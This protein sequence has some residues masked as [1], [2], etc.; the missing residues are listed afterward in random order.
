M[1]N[2]RLHSGSDLHPSH[3]Q[4]SNLVAAAR[5]AP[6]GGDIRPTPRPIRR[7]IPRYHPCVAALHWSA[8]VPAP[9]P[10]A[11]HQ[12]AS[13]VCDGRH[14]PTFQ[15]MMHLMPVADLAS[16]DIPNAVLRSNLSANRMFQ[17]WWRDRMSSP[18]DTWSSVSVPFSSFLEWQERP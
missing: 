15:L 18:G 17:K 16:A 2:I 8:C 3:T 13:C 14:P 1:T 9:R 12:S 7:S 4:S 10:N 5:T 6:G 11:T